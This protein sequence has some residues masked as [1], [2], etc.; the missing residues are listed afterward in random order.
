MLAAAEQSTGTSDLSSSLLQSEQSHP[1]SCQCCILDLFLQIQERLCAFSFLPLLGSSL[2][3]VLAWA[4][5]MS[6]MSCFWPRW[7]PDL[8]LKRERARSSSSSASATAPRFTDLESPDIAVGIATFCCSRSAG[9]PAFSHTTDARACSTSGSTSRLRLWTCEHS[10]L[11]IMLPTLIR[12][13]RCGLPMN[14]VLR[15]CCIAV[16]HTI[17]F[18]SLP[19][20]T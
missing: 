8:R 6:F 19:F 5:R 1:N 14:S 10:T 2:A 20:V 3:V 7:P 9:S 4:S 13:R 12:V 17:L 16:S 15:T 18:S 11:K